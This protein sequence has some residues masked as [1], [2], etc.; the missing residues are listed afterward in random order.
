MHTV[1]L[2]V[3]CAYQYVQYQ[4]TLRGPDSEILLQDG[5][6]TQLYGEGST[7]HVTYDNISVEIIH[8]TANFR[9]ESWS[10][11]LMTTQRNISEFLS[12]NSYLMI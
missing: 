7:V 4:L 8:A 10:D 1:Q 12:Y 5:P 6:H 11:M 9:F 3:V 2:P